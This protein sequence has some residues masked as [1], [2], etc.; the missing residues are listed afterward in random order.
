MAL[1]IGS[2]VSV[3]AGCLNSEWCFRFTLADTMPRDWRDDEV[4]LMRELADRIWTRHCNC[5]R[6]RS[7][8][9]SGNPRT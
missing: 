1:S 9:G 3:A 7:P 5:T 8:A 6:R 2:F 4:D